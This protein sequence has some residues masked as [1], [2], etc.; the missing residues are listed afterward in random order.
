MKTSKAQNVMP[1]LD[2]AAHKCKTISKKSSKE[3]EQGRCSCTPFCG[4]GYY[5]GV[6]GQIRSWIKRG[7]RKT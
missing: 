7:V 2:K 6:S 4:V 1:V 5:N 3:E